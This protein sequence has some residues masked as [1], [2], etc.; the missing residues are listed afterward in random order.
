MKNYFYPAFILVLSLCSGCSNSGKTI[1]LVKE[2]VPHSA[3]VI[4]DKPTGSVRKAADELVY[5]VRKA[6]GAELQ[7]Y[8]ES[9]T[10]RIP[11][12][13][14]K[15]LI[16]PSEAVK[17][18]GLDADSLKSEQFR[19]YADGRHLVFLGHDL[20]ESNATLWA[21]CDFL[22]RE[23]GVRWLWP[24]DLGI[25]VPKCSSITLDCP[26][27]RIDRPELQRRILRYWVDM[28]EVH[29]WAHH[30]RMGSRTTYK[31]G[32]AF[33]D[34]WD[35]YHE[36]HPD[37]FA[38][39]PQGVKQ[40]WPRPFLVK[41]NLGNPAVAD[42]I[43]QEW[44][45]AGKPDNWNV[46][47]NDGVGWCTSEQTRALDPPEL[48]SVS[49]EDIWR[50]RVSLTTRF[51]K[52]WNGLLVR[53]REM[54][55]NVTLSTYAYSAYR[56][57]PDNVKLE[58]GFVMGVVNTY[59]AYDSW[60]AWHNAGAQLL[61]R[62]NW[63]HISGCG[64]HL[65]LHDAGKFFKF[66]CQY[67]MIGFYFDSIM[68]YWSTQGP[69]YYLIARLNV[70]PQMSVDEII[71]EYASAFGQAA[72]AI[73]K[74]I[75][76]WEDFTN[77][78]A[79]TIPAGGSVSQDKNGLYERAV[80]EHNLPMHPLNGGWR[81]MPYLYTDDVLDAAYAILDDAANLAVNDPDEVGER[82]EFLRNG[83]RFL[84]KVRDVVALIWAPE[85]PARTTEDDVAAAIRDLRDFG[86]SITPSH[87]MW[88]DYIMRTLV[89]RDI[90]TKKWQD[91]DGM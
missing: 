69:F 62:P 68:G 70:H 9:E 17:K 1:V 52:F 14:D 65:P 15:V 72:P 89:R 47:P 33:G 49:A 91:L 53:M 7:I 32:H 57:A 30:H 74:Y 25:Y 90:L 83:L 43:L 20:D 10:D 85:L 55:P 73:E 42:R 50:G 27:D 46:S 29:D 19:T 59:H 28:S 5:H 4:A 45:E 31:F 18:L 16:G 22:E 81:T 44:I 39:P 88:G 63:W 35:K 80:R 75:V 86:E 3:I 26:V 78:A 51:I 61:L 58:P 6:T 76:F 71:A 13:F 84:A 66:S 11:D 54:N 23:L 82:I 12:G 56:E 36:D 87:S 37:Y 21:V 34:W 41:L 2:G 38:V 67:S 40:P 60:M 77:K 64:P 24:G 8:S 79:Y 48:S